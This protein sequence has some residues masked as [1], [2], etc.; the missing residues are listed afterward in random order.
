MKLSQGSENVLDT[1]MGC[2]KLEAT[3][4]NV[5]WAQPVL[6]LNNK[7]HEAAIK[8]LTQHFSSVISSE[9]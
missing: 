3:I 5:R 8:Y 7:L 9:A 4:P 2:E 6:I 1:V